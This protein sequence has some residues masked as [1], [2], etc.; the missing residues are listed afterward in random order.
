MLFM[1][2]AIWKSFALFGTFLGLS[3]VVF[4]SCALILLMT[5]GP[6]YNLNLTTRPD[7]VWN[8]F[9]T[10]GS[11]CITLLESILRGE[12]WGPQ[13]LQPMWTS[14]NT[15]GKS[16]GAYFVFI[17]VFVH[18]LFTLLATAFFIEAV[19]KAAGEDKQSQRKDR[20][21]NIMD[22]MNKLKE[23]FTQE[24]FSWNGFK[25]ILRM[26]PTLMKTLGLSM[27]QVEALFRQLVQ[28]DG[29]I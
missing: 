27:K 12:E 18:S 6:F 1:L 23:Y 14:G 4:Y 5:N 25:R 22:E 13:I 9:Q 3:A 8:R 10:I 19:M 24:R 28:E 17:A 7:A 15:R 29:K 21:L 20:L 16:I 2:H 11:S 26:H